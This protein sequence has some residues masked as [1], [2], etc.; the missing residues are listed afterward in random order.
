MKLLGKSLASVV[1]SIGLLAINLILP[2]PVQAEVKC[3]SG[4][5]NQYQNGSLERC[6]ISSNTTIQVSNFK[7][8]NSIYPCQ[9]GYYIFFDENAHFKSCVLSAAVQIRTGNLI[10]NCPEKHMVYISILKDGNQSVTCR[11]LS[12]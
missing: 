4:T 12:P 1:S 3:E 11:R 2:S 5:I 6:I 8:G 10:E 9:K 7:I